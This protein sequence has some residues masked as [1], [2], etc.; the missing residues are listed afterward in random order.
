MSSQSL[1]LSLPSDTSQLFCYT[2]PP[3]ATPLRCTH[4]Q[5]LPTPASF[6]LVTAAAPWSPRFAFLHIFAPQLNFT[7]TNGSEMS[8]SSNA[9]VLT[10]SSTATSI[11]NNYNDVWASGDA[12]RNWYLI[13]GITGSGDRAYG[14]FADT[15]FR[16][17]YLSAPITERTSG[18]TWLIAG[19][20]LAM[21]TNEIWTSA[22][23]IRWTR[24]NTSG[25]IFSPR[26]ST[27]AGMNSSGAMFVVSGDNALHFINDAWLSTDRAVTWTLVC[28]EVPFGGRVNARMS[29]VPSAQL[30]T[31]IITIVGG[32]RGYK[33][34]HDVWVSRD[35]A[36]SWY[37]VTESAN[38]EPRDGFIMAVTASSVL[39]L[40]LGYAEPMNEDR[41]YF[42]DMSISLNG[43]LDWYQCSQ[44]LPMGRRW[45]AGF[46]FDIDEHLIIASGQVSPIDYNDV[47]I[48]SVSFND[49]DALAEWCGGRGN[50][51]IPDTFGLQ[52]WPWPD[53][54][55]TSLLTGADFAMKHQ[56][57][58]QELIPPPPPLQFDSFSGEDT[59]IHSPPLYPVST[60]NTSRL[61]PT[62]RIIQLS[63]SGSLV[64]ALRSDRSLVCLDPT[65]ADVSSSLAT[66]CPWKS[67]TTYQCGIGRRSGADGIG[68]IG[69]GSS[70]RTVRPDTAD[71]FVF[72][73]VT[74]P[75]VNASA[76]IFLLL[77]PQHHAT[78]YGNS[79]LQ[80]NDSDADHYTDQYCLSPHQHSNDSAPTRLLRSVP[81]RR[82]IVVRSILRTPMQSVCGDSSK[83]CALTMN[84][85]IICW[86]SDAQ[87]YS[88]ITVSPPSY[89]RFAQLTCGFEPAASIMNYACALTANVGMTGRIICWNVT[90][91]SNDMLYLA[92][93]T[94]WMYRQM[95]DSL[96]VVLQRQ[97]MDEW[98]RD[99]SVAGQTECMRALP[100]QPLSSLMDKQTYHSTAAYPV[101]TSLTTL[102]VFKA[103]SCVHGSDLCSIVSTDNIVYGVTHHFTAP[104]LILSTAN[105]TNTGTTLQTVALSN[106]FYQTSISSRTVMSDGATKPY[107]T[108]D[109]TLCRAT[110]RS[111]A[112][113]ARN[114]FF[115]QFDVDANNTSCGISYDPTLTTRAGK[116]VCNNP[117]PS[118]LQLFADY[119]VRHV[120]LVVSA[121]SNRP[122]N[123]V[124]ARRD[125]NGQWQCDRP[126]A[127]THVKANVNISDIVPL[128]S[129]LPYFQSF[130]LITAR[131]TWSP[132]YFGN[133]HTH[134]RPF[135]FIHVNGSTIVLPANSLIRST[136]WE[137]SQR[138]GNE[139]WA[140]A[141]KIN[142][143]L[144]CGRSRDGQTSA[145]GVFA[146]TSFDWTYS[147][148]TTFL[149]NRPDGPNLGCYWSKQ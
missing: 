24:V 17:L 80:W 130:Q 89:M 96:D 75:T 27:A 128:A 122:M 2:V 21:E 44:H 109:N 79:S 10:A 55:T 53:A 41:R 90:G 34:E 7:H 119:A 19:R 14:E 84:G 48:S 59:L 107:L 106:L 105:A 22:D 26:H 68:W 148:G 32:R 120:R 62:V 56:L 104:L 134:P 64:C 31:D 147:L 129:G 86:H 66:Y 47:Y 61:P 9:L 35:G 58:S 133:L 98:A 77:W 83:A 50:V 121:A 3:P 101:I 30:Q 145:F 65:R 69:S 137:K 29:I 91:D 1:S 78:F 136:Y 42:T 23:M 149:Q 52:H 87:H 92:N 46:A 100:N 36:V 111:W 70:D 85:A 67:N 73:S 63:A 127:L 97:L 57:T 140:S 43:G 113:I 143:F 37:C 8:L 141:D 40:A 11:A 15:S 95:F 12:G 116:F 81:L 139:V 117:L 49:T 38:F 18:R 103:V 142:W 74:A 16:P 115:D 102:L 108:F 114:A 45:Y 126:S 94:Y 76:G 124:C 71:G 60:V 25:S 144:I 54:S 132:R 88:P 146:N 125:D 118:S 138:P 6:T 20:T 4:S 5:Q 123:G 135:S 110:N 13:S 112:W 99:T 93:I 28:S 131:A 82:H 39:V 33:F 72:V 51:V